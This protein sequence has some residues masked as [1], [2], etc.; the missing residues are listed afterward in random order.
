MWIGKE[1]IKNNIGWCF[2]NTYSRLPDIMLTRISPVPVKLPKLV[3]L[4][5]ELSKELGLNFSNMSN[6]DLA[7]L[8][9]GNFLPEGSESI[10]QAYA[11]HQFGHFTMLGDGRAILIGEHISKKKE[12]FD[13]QF[14]GSGK[15]PFSRNGDGR[16]ALGPML[17]EYIISEAM[18]YLKIPTT[19]SLAVVETGESVIR[20]TSLPG[21]ILTRV[22]SSH[23]RVGTFQYIAA[24]QDIKS[25]KTLVDYTINR[26]YPNVKSSKNQALDLLKILIEK[27]TKLV[28]DWMRVG[29]IHGV[30]NTDNMT[31]SGETIDYGPCAFMDIYDPQTVFSSIDELGRYA[32]F[33]QPTIT[34]WNLAR[35]AECLI[36]LIDKNKNKAIEIAT[37]TINDFEKNYEKNWINMMRDKL[38]LFGENLNDQV[39]ILDLLTWMHKNKVDYTNTFCF[40]M[41]EKIEKNEIYNDENFLTWKQKWQERLKLNNNTPEKYLRL[42]RSVNPLI[43]PRNHKVEEALEAANNGNLDLVKNLIKILEKPYENQGN[44]TS[45]Q[46]PALLSNEKYQTFCGT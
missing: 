17:R 19:R 27:Q 7:T 28:V 30:M 32:Y 38:G 36:P 46:S 24:R 31:I 33:N 25:L 6:E 18:H 23:M 39:L 43:I 15:T 1:N 21:A 34:K 44:F 20:E 5:Y 10:A 45:Y 4:N 12:R 26:H 29:F 9:S 40:L 41:N 2:D 22:A 16:A 13:I 42:M 35:F 3:I 14:K 11:G 37:E 8:F